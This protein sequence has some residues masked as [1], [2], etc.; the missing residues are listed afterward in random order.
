[1][2]VPTFRI[3]ASLEVSEKFGMGGW[4][5]VAT[6]LSNLNL[7]PSFIELESGLGYDND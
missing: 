1:M 5:V 4:V 3:L 7:N 2:S 6:T